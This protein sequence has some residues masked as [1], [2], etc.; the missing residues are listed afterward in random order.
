MKKFTNCE[1]EPQDYTSD[2]IDYVCP[3]CSTGYYWDSFERRCVECTIE[4]CTNCVQEYIC[5]EC[6]AD[7]ILNPL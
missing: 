2:T 6:D 1:F 4:D 3:E 7:M 5:S